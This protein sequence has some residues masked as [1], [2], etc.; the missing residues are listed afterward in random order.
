M[1]SR[2]FNDAQNCP[3]KALVSLRQDLSTAVVALYPT[4]SLLFSLVFTNSF[5]FNLVGL[6]RADTIDPTG[7]DFG[8]YP[9][10]VGLQTPRDND[11]SNSETIFKYSSD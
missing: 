2:K 9:Q 1:E 5:C 6:N 8:A 11:M 10:N 7:A 4:E 3:D